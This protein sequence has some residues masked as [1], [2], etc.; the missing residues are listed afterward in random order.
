MTTRTDTTLPEVLLLEDDVATTSILKIWLKGTCNLTAVSDAEG[1]FNAI[2]HL[3]SKNHL[4]DLM[5]FDINIPFPWNGLTLMKEIC[6]RYTAYKDVPFVAQTAY[7]MPKD[8]DRL[9]E[10]G[11]CDYLPKPLDRELM[12]RTVL[13][14][15]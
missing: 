8:R 7:A 5:L 1:T 6:I 12:I 3:L 2:E 9:L 11:F 13:K 14:H 4:F 10:A 15:L